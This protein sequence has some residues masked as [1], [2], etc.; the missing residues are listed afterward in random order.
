VDSLW[1]QSLRIVAADQVD[2]DFVAE[3]GQVV[4]HRYHLEPAQPEP[5]N[6][7]RGVANDDK[8]CVKSYRTAGIPTAPPWP[9]RLASAIDSVSAGPLPAGLTLERPQPE[10]G[11]ERLRQ[12]N[13]TM[14]GGESDPEQSDQVVWLDLLLPHVT[15]RA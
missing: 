15:D 14:A 2:I 11:D 5:I 12:W 6:D 3:D 4:T 1:F 10:V 9:E 7:N 8:D 13:L